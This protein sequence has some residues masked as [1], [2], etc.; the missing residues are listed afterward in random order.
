LF[1]KN[2]PWLSFFSFAIYQL[3]FFICHCSLDATSAVVREKWK[4]TIEKST[5]ENER[6]NAK[7]ILPI[8]LMGVTDAAD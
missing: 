3:S 5:M 2:K 4:M 6:Q 7:L 8:Y 1:G